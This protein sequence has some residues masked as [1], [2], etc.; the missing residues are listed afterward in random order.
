M[1]LG[2]YAPRLLLLTTPSYDYNARFHDPSTPEHLRAGFPDPTG[3][4]R[5]VFRHSDHKF[6]WTRAEFSTW[7]SEAAREWGY[8]LVECDS[9]GRCSEEDPRDPLLGGASQVALFRRREQ[10]DYTEKRRLAREHHSSSISERQHALLAKHVYDVDVH[11]RRSAS[12]QNIHQCMHDAFVNDYTRV[13]T[14]FQLWLSG[15][16]S[17]AC[18]GWLSVLLDAIDSSRDLS[19]IEIEGEPKDEWNVE[20][21]GDLPDPPGP[22][23][24]LSTHEEIES[25]D[26]EYDIE[27]TNPPTD[28]TSSSAPEEWQRATASSWGSERLE[29]DLASSTSSSLDGWVA[30]NESPRRNLE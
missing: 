21:H 26:D 19:L 24:H 4:T 29:W 2:V 28:I 22:E 23:D 13:K 10:G 12:L 5:R 30:N 20:Y 16:V 7:C 8:N 25:D 27:D 3:R 6:E 15:E 9:R 17:R 1:L 14:V 18:G 11:A